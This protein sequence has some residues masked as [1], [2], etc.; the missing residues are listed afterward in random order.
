MSSNQIQIGYVIL[1]HQFPEHVLRLA[2][3]LL[4]SGGV[5][6]IHYDNRAANEDV[7]KIRGELA[8]YGDKIVWAQRTNVGWGTWSIVQ[9]TLNALEALDRS[10]HKIDY[11]HLMS[12][13]DYP[14]KSLKC[15][16][17]FIADNFGDEFLECTDMASESWVKG[18]LSHERYQYRHFFNWKTQRLLFDNSFAFQRRFN[19]KREFPKSIRPYMGSQWWT[20]T[21]NAIQ[22]VLAS[23]R[24]KKLVS[25]FRSVWIPDEMFVQSIVAS[26]GFK[27]SPYLNLTL[28]QFNDKGNPLVYYND[29]TNYLLE[30]PFFF[31]RKISPHAG[32]LRD[33]IDRVILSDDETKK[34]MRLPVGVRT[35]HYDE[36]INRWA[37]PKE[38][39]R[40]LGYEKNYWLGDLSRLTKPLIVIAGASVDEVNV[41]SSIIRSRFDFN[42]HGALFANDSINFA[43]D[44]D[45][46]AGYNRKDVSL[47]DNRG[48]NFLFDVISEDASS[49]ITCFNLPWNGSNEILEKLAWIPSV[50]FIF[51]SGSS[52]SPVFS[53]YNNEMKSAKIR[54]RRAYDNNI[55]LNAIAYSKG[56]DSTLQKCLKSYFDYLDST[57][58]ILSTGTCQLKKL[59][60]R[61]PS[62]TKE[63]DNYLRYLKVPNKSNLI[64]V[65]SDSEVS[66][67]HLPERKFKESFLNRVFKVA[68]KRRVP[69]LAEELLHSLGVDQT[70]PIVIICGGSTEETTFVEK[71]LLGCGLRSMHT[72]LH[73]AHIPVYRP[74]L[75][76][77][78]SKNDGDLAFDEET[79]VRR[80]EL[81][82]SVT[83]MLARASSINIA[84][85]AR[86]NSVLF[87]VR[88]N[89]LRAYREM[90]SK[91]HS[92]IEAH[93]VDHVALRE[94]SND[95]LKQFVERLGSYHGSLEEKCIENE[96]KI[97][98]LNLMSRNWLTRLQL[99]L[100][101]FV[102]V[103]AESLKEIYLQEVV[104]LTDPYDIF[105]NPRLL[106]SR[107][108]RGADLAEQ[109]TVLPNTSVRP[110]KIS[111][112]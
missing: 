7:I 53:S 86:K 65:S 41:V 110:R 61:N 77:L 44:M 84:L 31:A 101:E 97:I 63:L 6:S 23:G 22:V 3:L 48:T 17:K 70:T 55:K 81:F 30:Q 38:N 18:G 79:R 60:L 89:L 64:R 11:V 13:S 93:T 71:I 54:L 39:T 2:Q 4:N 68:E 83:P 92:L 36:F 20:L 87:C 74:E 108:L 105:E 80:S 37:K 100:Q 43:D 21:W 46:Y 78:R 76:H 27:I 1:A 91:R 104:N 33:G 107:V 72:M 5:V 26:N 58:R 51:I 32:K 34:E 52:L 94:N 59:E 50:K 106:L 75:A 56:R 82:V 62:W 16:E 103:D 88:G 67:L 66:K 49:S 40:L 85:A 19:I 96:Q 99:A 14:I 90:L 42:V 24:D 73:S 29:H 35:S 9:A 10:Q 47:R 98:D 112:G 109:A 12:G 25:F 28:Y 102:S 111:I 69:I 45:E 15:F 57:F 8:K 95:S